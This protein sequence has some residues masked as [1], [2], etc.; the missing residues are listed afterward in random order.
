MP[1]TIKDAFHQISFNLHKY[2]E[3]GVIL[4]IL[5]IRA[6]RLR[7]QDNQIFGCLMTRFC[8]HRSRA[9]HVLG[10]HQGKFV[11]PIAEPNKAIL[12]EA[13]PVVPGQHYPRNHPSE[14]WNSKFC[15]WKQPQ[16]LS[17]YSWVEHVLGVNVVVPWEFIFPPSVPSF[18]L[19]PKAT[20]SSW[21]VPPPTTC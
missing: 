17:V 5:L 8:A 21:P 7:I 12:S 15:L 2:C 1:D 9:G 14:F 19:T 3:A 10:K 13:Q 4:L 16:S 20:P 18:S 11:N 6:L